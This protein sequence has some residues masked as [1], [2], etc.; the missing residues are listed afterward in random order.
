M[1]KIF[2]QSDMSLYY[3]NVF[4][5]DAIEKYFMFGK[6]EKLEIGKN[7][8]I[9]LKEMEFFEKLEQASNAVDQFF[10]DRAH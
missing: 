5:D 9:K 8:F 1:V 7:H 3:K 6:N 10:E 4:K 2:S